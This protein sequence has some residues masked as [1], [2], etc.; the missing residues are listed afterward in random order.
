MD[1]Q[2]TSVS[3]SLQPAYLLHYHEFQESSYIVDAFTLHHGRV[4]LIAKSARN[5]R[6]AI[7][8]LYQ[9]FRPLLLSWVGS[10]ELR[11]LTGIE[12]SGAAITLERVRLACGYYINELLLRLLGKDQQH[13]HVFALYS[14]ALSELSQA[15]IDHER[16]LRCFELQVLDALGL[17]P[18]FSHCTAD[19]SPIVPD[20]EYLYHPANAIAVPIEGSVGLGLLKEK[21]R[22]GIDGPL[23][24]STINYGTSSSSPSIHADGITLDEGVRVRGQTLIAMEQLN[25]DTD[26]TLQECR[27]IMRRIVRLQIGERPLKSRELFKTLAGESK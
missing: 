23:A 10:G 16:V 8:S 26:T 27:L 20:T 14:L 1:S 13:E 22:M 24:S 5:S 25:F 2:D 21:H 17:L 15:D 4:A 11:T 3:T 9:P 7:R 19:G 12:D 6:P 18:V